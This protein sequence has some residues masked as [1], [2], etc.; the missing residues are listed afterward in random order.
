MFRTQQIHIVLRSTVS[1]ITASFTDYS[2]H[3][4]CCFWQDPQLD[5]SAVDARPVYKDTIMLSPGLQQW[6]TRTHD[7]FLA[8]NV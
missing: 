2:Q 8:F 3:S 4:D 5:V 7:V 6:P 1:N